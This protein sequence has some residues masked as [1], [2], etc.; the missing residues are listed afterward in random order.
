MDENE[1]TI[2]DVARVPGA[3]ANPIN[4]LP[5]ELRE[6]AARLDPEKAYT[7]LGL[8]EEGTGH[9]ASLLTVAA[10][11]YKMGVTFDDTLDHLQAGYSPDRMDYESAPRRAVVRV[12]E[13]EG[14]L[15][16]LTDADADSA[17]DAREEML[18]RF[19]R[20]PASALVEASP[21]KLTTPA[22]DII[23]NLFDEDHIINIQHT[24]LEYGTLVK[25]SEIESFIEKHSCRLEDYK[26]LNPANF[27]NVGGVPNPLDKDNRVST[28]C[29]ENVKAR[30]WMVL[31]IDSKEDAAVERFNTFAVAMA[32]FAPLV[33]AVD[34][35][36]KSIHFWYD[37][38]N[39]KPAIRRGF[40]N[41][42]CLHG[43]DRRMAVK[44][45]IARMPNT[46]SA[47]EGRGPQKVLYFD[48]DRTATPAGWD[49]RGFEGV[50]LENKHLE[51]FYNG[52]NK[53]FLTRDNLESWVTLDRT[54]VRSHL[55]EKGIR[56]LP[57]EGE[58][59]S[60]VEKVINGI[61]LNKNVE[62]VF[63]GASGRHAGL[64]EE[65]GHRIIVKKSPTFIK[66]R[67]GK[68]ET[69]HSFLVGLLG[70]EDWQLEIFYGWL[71][72]SL[73]KLRNGGKRCA[74]WGPCQMLHII[75]KGN[76]GKTLI[77]KD[78]LIP[79]FA[80]RAAKGDPLF[81]RFPDMHNPDTFGCE[82]IYL[83]DSPVLETNYSFRK[84]FGERIKS[85]V[86]GIGDGM[87][88]MQQGRINIRPWWRLVRLM[89]TEPDILATL[90]PFDEGIEDKMILLHGEKMKHGPLGKEMLLPGWYDRVSA[91]IKDELPAFI[92]FLLEEFE[93]PEGLTDEE[94]RYPTKSF[95][96]EELMAEISQGSPEQY[97]LHRIDTD[98]R[99]IFTPLAMS[100]ID[101]EGDEPLPWQGS[102]ESLYDALSICGQRV[103]QTRFSKACPSPRIL[104]SQL[105][106]IEKDYPNRVGYSKR[107]EDWPNKR[108][109]AEY[110]V[111]FPPAKKPAN[112]VEA[113][114][115]EMY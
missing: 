37:A 89:N 25:V 50:I 90:P 44:S 8:K 80:D 31:E 77:L 82:L 96:S 99:G 101:E 65:N 21:G 103:S 32:E 43:A 33:L 30:R 113:A 55:A 61:Q 53:T 46:S 27:K 34:T 60:E 114:L 69:I 71:S 87:R 18:I 3:G 59:L 58:N 93:L 76:A 29:N 62:G 23:R 7:L 110:W 88:G 112:P 68:W 70:H 9:N 14:D 4:H 17:P 63:I 22:A 78:I 40:F 105:R 54:S 49:L 83:D 11:C 16:K 19:R 74:V 73:K 81:K 38:T 107:L 12:W 41:L 39:L 42:A 98:G 57:L 102:V 5:A 6:R 56:Q 24:A 10:T 108:H 35:G 45:Q 104:L 111:I 1:I 47:G 2:D 20:T 48:P 106:H 92:H 97:I 72:D 85:H 51:Y 64:Y 100:G 84:E 36:N 75:G 79:C 109:G 52:E 115:G 28:R 66:A 15:G 67:R 13:A 94:G 86:V 26:F 95:K 91:R